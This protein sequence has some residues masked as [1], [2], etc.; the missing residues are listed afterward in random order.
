IP[1][2]TWLPDRTAV[3]R[4]IAEGQIERPHISRG[5]D[6]IWR[7]PGP[8]PSEAERKRIMQAEPGQALIIDDDTIVMTLPEPK[9]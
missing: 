1:H 3:E 9:K 4:A 2:I 6:V 5:D 7:W 8:R